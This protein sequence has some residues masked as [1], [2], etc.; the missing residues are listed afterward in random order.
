MRSQVSLDQF[1]R[2]LLSMV[3][4][5]TF[6]GV[7]LV[8]LIFYIACTPVHEAIEEILPHA[9]SAEILQRTVPGLDVLVRDD[10]TVELMW[11]RVSDA[12]LVER[13]RN[14]PYLPNPKWVVVSAD[15]H[16]ALG[17]I[18]AVLDRLSQ[19]G[20]DRIT[21]RTSKFPIHHVDQP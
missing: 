17:R 19:A 9:V 5:I 1:R 4:P 16:T 18:K 10:G 21:L 11:K 7:W 13:L 14:W 6:G 3:Y 2:I 20:V 15:R 12:D 8:L